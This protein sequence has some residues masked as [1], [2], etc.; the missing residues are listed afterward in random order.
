MDPLAGLSVSTNFG[1][2][3][4]AIV[5]V[6]LVASTIAGMWAMRYIRDMDDYVVA[7]RSVRTYLGVASM[8]AA[9]LGLVTVMYSA[10]K[11]FSCGFAA[12]AIAALAALAGFIVGQTGFIVVP[13]RKMGVMTIPEFY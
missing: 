10:Q 9:E 7:G 5:I 11:G 2:A 13:L 1:V 12:F 8:I 3:D 6:F 4:W